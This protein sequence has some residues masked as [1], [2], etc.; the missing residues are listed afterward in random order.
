M[1]VAHRRRPVAVA[2]AYRRRLA[3]AC[4]RQAAEAPYPRPVAV[5]PC[6]RLV[7]AVVCPHPVAVAPCRRLVAAVA[8]P[9]PVA[10]APCRRLV[11]AVACPHQ[12]AV[13]PCLRLER[14]AVA[15]YRRPLVEAVAALSRHAVGLADA[16]AGRMPVVR[17]GVDRQRPVVVAVAARRPGP[18]AALPV[19]AVR[20]TPRRWRQTA[21]WPAWQVSDDGTSC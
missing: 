13:V 3:V 4:L 9:R 2:A 21:R 19:A 20:Q 7:A 14:V 8:C 5:V 11:A 16:R 18:A 17:H 1:A 6:R 12:V 10:E 15:P